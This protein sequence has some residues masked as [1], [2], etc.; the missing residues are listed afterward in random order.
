MG[1]EASH[2]ANGCQSFSLA[3]IGY[4]IPMLNAIEMLILVDSEN[5]PAS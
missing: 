3:G 5:L 2:S 4:S 1:Y